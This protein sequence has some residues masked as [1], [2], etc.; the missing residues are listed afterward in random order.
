MKCLYCDKELEHPFITF[1]PDKY[2]RRLVQKF[3]SASCCDTW[4]RLAMNRDMAEGVIYCV[5]SHPALFSA[6]CFSRLREL[7][8][9]HRFRGLTRTEK[10]MAVVHIC[11]QTG[12][13]E[14]FRRGLIAVYKD[15]AACK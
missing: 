8:L 4:L 6:D 12:Y 14:K 7:V 1:F 5:R 10:D 2:G 9:H 11:I 15:S 13:N 3:C